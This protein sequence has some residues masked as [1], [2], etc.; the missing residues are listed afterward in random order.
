MCVCFE[1]SATRTH[2]NYSPC[3]GS[4]FRLVF[5]IH[6]QLRL[7]ISVSFDGLRDFKAKYSAKCFREEIS[8]FVRFAE[9]QKDEMKISRER[10]NTATQQRNNMKRK[11]L[12]RLEFFGFISIISSFR[13]GSE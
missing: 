11:S 8:L 1:N 4:A 9:L 3:F 5:C 6:A 2:L 7:N 12:Q 13:S 10:S